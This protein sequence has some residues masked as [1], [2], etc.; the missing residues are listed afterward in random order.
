MLSHFTWVWLFCDPMDCSPP[1]SSVHGIFQ[2]GIVEW[3]VYLITRW[4][5]S[6]HQWPVSRW[7]SELTVPFLHAVSSYCLKKFLPTGCQGA[8]GPL[9][10]RLSSPCPTASIRNKANF[11]FHQPVLF[12]GLWAMSSQTPHTFGN[13]RTTRELSNTIFIHP[14]H[15]ANISHEP[16]STQPI[17]R[18]LYCCG[19]TVWC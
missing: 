17:Y 19:K 2:A 18:P 5:W 1:G 8:S 15:L 12:I 7:L 6:K 11:P 3:V 4:C 10:R 16:G 9:D 13:K 14:T